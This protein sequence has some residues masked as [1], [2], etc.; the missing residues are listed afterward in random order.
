MQKILEAGAGLN[1]MNGSHRQRKTGNYEEKLGFS[2]TQENQ[3]QVRFASCI[4]LKEFIWKKP[5]AD[6]YSR[7]QAI[8]YSRFAFSPF[9]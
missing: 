7:E 9:D 5:M 8:H 6:F 1:D 3:R 2:I 4:A